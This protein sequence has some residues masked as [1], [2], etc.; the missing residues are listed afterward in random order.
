VAD[1]VEKLRSKLLPWVRRNFPNYN[2]VL[3]QD[4]APAHTAKATQTFL[5]ENIPFWPKTMWP[6]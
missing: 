3:Q 2:G 4:G 6:P 5:E 1:Y